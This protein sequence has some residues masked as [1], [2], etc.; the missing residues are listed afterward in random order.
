[1]PHQIKKKVSMSDGPQDRISAN[2][3]CLHRPGHLNTYKATNHG[4][5]SQAHS[6]LYVAKTNSLGR[7]MTALLSFQFPSS[8][9]PDKLMISFPVGIQH[10]TDW[11]ASG[12]Q[13]KQTLMIP[14]KPLL[15]PS[16]VL[17]SP[18]T[19]IYS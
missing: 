2:P 12:C 11:V 6:Q 18:L 8:L 10:W 5:S 4:H 9:L 3:F 14:H 19:S 17:Y 16:P 13:P 1:M 7:R 15:F